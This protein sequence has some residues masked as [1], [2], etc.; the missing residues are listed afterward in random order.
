MRAYAAHMSLF[1]TKLGPVVVGHRGAPLVAAE[2]TL[3]SFRA[4]A[5]QGASWVELDARLCGDGTIVVHHDARTAD[6]VALVE[7]S[8][9]ELAAL[10]IESLSDVLEGLPPRLGVDVECKNLPGQPDFFDDLRLGLAVRDLL[11]PLRGRRPLLVSSFD[12]LLVEA[13]SAALPT[14]LLYGD[15]L[16][17]DG[18]AEIGREVGA[19][20]LCPHHGADLDADGLEQVHAAGFAVLVW[21]VDDPGHARAFAGIGVDAV[22]TNDPAGI[23]A[24]L[25]P[26][27]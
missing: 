5:E 12:P 18:A 17:L 14:G 24:A 8:A 4:A 22:C 21:T 13:I 9:A 19:A 15:T 26:P 6:G 25:R 10:G 2:N 7:R 16:A 27:R 1:Q 23:A 3:E 20:V 11:A